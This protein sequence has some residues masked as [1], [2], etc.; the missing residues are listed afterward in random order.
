MKKTEYYNLDPEER[1]LLSSFKRGEWKSIK[2]LQKEKVRAKK[3]AEKTLA[4]HLK[5]NS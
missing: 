3:I 4:I 1:E 5:L 2:N